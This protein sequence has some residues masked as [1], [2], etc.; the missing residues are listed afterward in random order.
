MKTNNDISNNKEDL[1][2]K[3]LFKD[4]TP[5]TPREGLK[6][7]IMSKVLHEW[8]VSPKSEQFKISDYIK[9]SLICIPVI[10]LVGFALHYFSLTPYI[11][12]YLS[13]LNLD[14]FTPLFHSMSDLFSQH[15]SIANLTF[16]T[17][18]GALLLMGLDRLFGKNT[19]HK[20]AI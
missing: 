3:D 15:S 10:A 5:E 8:Y 2:L 7:Q 17:I 16:L 13:I 14:I 20:Q 9:W 1:L 12:N 19:Q 4:F 11:S 6:Y 18:I